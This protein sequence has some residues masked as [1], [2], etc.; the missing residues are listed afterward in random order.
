MSETRSAEELRENSI[1]KF[2]ATYART[3]RCTRTTDLREETTGLQCL[4]GAPIVRRRVGEE[5]AG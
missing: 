2:F 5:R 4:C 1:T 3:C